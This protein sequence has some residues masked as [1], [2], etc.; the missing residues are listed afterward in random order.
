MRDAIDNCFCWSDNWWIEEN[1]AWFVDGERDVLYKLNLLTNQYKAVKEL[2]NIEEIKFRQ[3]PRCIKYK[4][5]IVCMPDLGRYIWI[6]KFNQFRKIE[7]NNL[8]NKRIEINNFWVFEERLFAI[9]VG[10]KQIIEINVEKQRIDN[11]YSLSVPNAKIGNSIKVGEKIF[12]VSVISSQVYEFNLYTKEV[13]THELATVNDKLYAICFDGRK[14]WLS[15]YNK[16][17]Y[18]WSPEKNT[19]EVIEDFPEGFGIYDYSAKTN[20][21]L[22]NKTIIYE[23][24]IFKD[25]KSVGKYIWFIPFQTNKILYVEKKSSKFFELDIIEENETKESLIRNYMAHKY[26]VLYI[27]KERYIGLFSL[28]NSSVLEI[29]TESL[30]VENKKYFFSDQNLDKVFLHRIFAEC[31]HFDIM[32]YQKKLLIGNSKVNDLESPN[33]GLRIYE[34]IQ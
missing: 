10:L 34:Y 8:N 16:A 25:I 32:I 27:N 5:Y 9:S 21:L 28:K 1:N 13:I 24:P 22:D 12:I 15:G 18:I 11:Y 31:N 30:R 17:V 7:I 2:P 26:L 23:T 19:I 6:Y 4:D 3:N 29:D 20:N 14:F 33:I